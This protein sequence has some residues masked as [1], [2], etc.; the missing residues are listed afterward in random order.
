VKRDAFISRVGQ[1]TLSAVLPDSPTVPPDLPD[2]GD[3]DLVNR[4]RTRAQAVNVVVHGPVSRHGVPRAVAGVAGGHNATSFMA[5]DELPAPGVAAT[6]VSD[7]LV[8]VD[9]EAPDHDRLAHNETYRTLD[10]GVTGAVA[11]FAESGSVVLTHGP[12]RPR[13]AS[14]VP[15]IHIALLPIKDIHRSLAYWAH[16]FPALAAET[17]NLVV[18][19]GPSRTGDIEQHLNLGV[20][21]PRHVHIVLIK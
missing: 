17:T 8:R 10:V 20:H 2:A 19:T 6:L 13:M 18:V 7:G 15:E 14:I 5:W 11:G 12:G 4:F 21:G 3:I 9:H 1:A 16:E